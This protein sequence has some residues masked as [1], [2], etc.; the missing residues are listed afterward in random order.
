MKH[1][2]LMDQDGQT[3]VYVALALVALLAFVALA[4]DGGHIYAE[5]RRMQNAADAGALAGAYEMCFGSAS[6]IRTTA[7][8]Y[9]VDRNG[10][11]TV[12]VNPQGNR[13]T[14][15]ASQTANTFFAGVV[16]INTVDV[17]ADAT[18]ACGTA[19]SACNLWPIA[20]DIGRWQSQRACGKKFIL[21]DSDNELDCVRW[22]CD[23]DGDGIPD[24]PLDMRAWVDF[25]AAMVPG[26]R[27]PCD[28]AGCGCDELKYR[29]RGYNNHGEACQSWVQIPYCMVGSVGAGVCSAAWQTAEDQAGRIVRFPLYDGSCTPGAGA[30]SS[31]GSEG[32]NVT[33]FGCVRVVGTYHL[34]PVLDPTHCQNGPKVILVEVPCVNGQPHPA[35]ASECGS[36]T[37]GD[38]G[39]GSVRAVSLT[40]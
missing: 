33:D 12:D 34:C 17:S 18:A 11:Q 30:G 20:F 36:T 24:T 14:V 10:A 6:Q 19:T 28:G 29:I 37:G 13:V 31:C 39:P 15:T 3:L 22:N 8:E 38:P 7:W 9:A 25:T 40:D 35:C 1:F 32:Y 5:R 16:G 23:A 21:W 27:D 26:Q 2:R 4:I